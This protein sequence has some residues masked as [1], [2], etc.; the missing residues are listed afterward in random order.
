MEKQEQEE[1]IATKS[2]GFINRDI[3]IGNDI[4]LPPLANGV[5]IKDRL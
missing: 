4:I 2:D 3:L 5:T 1:E